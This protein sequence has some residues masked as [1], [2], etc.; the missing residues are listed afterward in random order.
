MEKIAPAE[1]AEEMKDEPFK[2]TFVTKPKKPTSAWIYFNTEMVA[3]LKQKEAMDQKEAFTKSADIWKG[4]SD[5]DKVPYTTKS[6]SDE[7]RYKRQNRELT[8]NGFFMTIDGQKSTDLHV[9]PKK[10]FGDTVLL[11]KKPLSA[12]LFYTTENVN[13]LKESENCSHTEAMKK[14]GQLWN[15]L[16]GPGKQKY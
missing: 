12:Y 8:D 13:K 15:S 1:P 7:E 10:K 14:C 4:M 16:E 9:D 6:K 3:K 2:S 5:E 11:P